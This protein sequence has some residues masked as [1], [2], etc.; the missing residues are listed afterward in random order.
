MS[1]EL[2]SAAP[3]MPGVTP[4]PWGG[5]RRFTAARIALGRAGHSLPTAAHLQFQLAHAQAR[6]AVHVALHATQISSELQAAGHDT[7]MLHSAAP[8]RQTYLQ[9]P[10]LGRHL[11]KESIAVLR[12]WSEHN[13]EAQRAWAAE[14]VAQVKEEPATRAGDT[15]QSALPPR[16]HKPDLCFVVAD[17]LSALAVQTHAVDFLQ[18]MQTLLA[19]DANPWR[20]APICVVEQARVAIGDDIGER[21]DAKLV[22]VLI[23]ER[24][25]LSSP[26]SMGIYM[27]WAPRVG[28]TDA[29]RNCISNVRP[30]GLPAPEAAGTL[31]RLMRRARQLQLTGVELK[32]EGAAPSI[33]P[34]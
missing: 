10:D 24:P 17:G 13:I 16:L 29:E 12:T 4:Q 25:G 2:E 11:D 22:V 8:N 9:R 18:H 19:N 6:D 7:L 3:L 1:E 30:A 15:E 23:G 33:N 5:L 21:L 31:Y 32:D 14:H 26:D 28:R 34:T 20:T 27:T